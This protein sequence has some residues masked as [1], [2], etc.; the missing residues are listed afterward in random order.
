MPAYRA[1]TYLDSAFPAHSTSFSLNFFNQQRTVGCAMNH[2]FHLWL[3]YILF[4]HGMSLRCIK[5]QV[6]ISLS[7]RY[8]SFTL[9][10]VCVCVC[11]L[12]C[13]CVHVCAGA[14]V[15]DHLLLDAN[16]KIYFYLLHFCS[17]DPGMDLRRPAILRGGGGIENRDDC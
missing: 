2:N 10:C 15:C 3:E 4:R 6:S 12:A 1:S 14:C 9:P 5:H 11:M 8:T 16:K 7:P 17:G 13:V